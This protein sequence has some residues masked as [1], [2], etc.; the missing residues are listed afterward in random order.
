MKIKT[1]KQALERV[2]VIEETRDYSLTRVEQAIELLW[3]PLKNIKVI[4]IAGT[5]GKWSTSK[6]CFA[7]LKRAWCS[8][9]AF[10]QPHLLDIKERFITEKWEITEDEFL[11]CLNRI[12]ELD[13]DFSFF[14]KAFLMSCL[15]FEM[16]KVDFAIMEVWF[17]GLLDS[18]NVVSPIITAIT[19]IWIDH[20]KV[21]WN[22]IEE[23]S[24][25]KAG[26]IKSWIPIVYNYENSIIRKIAEE[27]NAPIIFTKNLVETNLIW[28]YQ[29]RNAGIAFEICKYIKINENTILEW[30]QKVKHF[31][32]LQ[33]ITK[34]LVIDWAHNEQWLQELL[35][36]LQ[37]LEKNNIQLCFGQ[38]KWKDWSK[39]LKVFWEPSILSF[40]KESPSEEWR[41]Q[42]L[43]FILVQNENK[44]MVENADILR[45]K[46]LENISVL[47][48]GFNH[49]DI[50]IH[51]PDEIFKLSQ[52]NK[53]I[54]YVVF[55][56]LYMI[57]EF[58]KFDR[59]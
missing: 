38:K 53:N 13:L 59:K 23:I 28:E 32:R 58:L 11:E 6:M 56:S 35:K 15:F 44:L 41:R 26:I 20:T 19:S 45:K 12:L 29:R 51:R 24:L 36:Y 10:T 14:E 54:L 30:L 39:I 5:N 48:E 18:T 16:R 34:N 7:V 47:T 22:T 17:G 49:L 9:W 1:Y 33:Y 3:N 31:G 4:H 8:V 46:I 57:W 40:W 27:K 2:F 25:Q 55:W 52:K 37:S 50:N 42:R 43:A 21:L